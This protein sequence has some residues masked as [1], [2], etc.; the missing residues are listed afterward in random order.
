MTYARLAVSA[1]PERFVDI[2]REMMWVADHQADPQAGDRLSRIICKV[3]AMRAQQ[4]AAAPS[5][6]RDVLSGAQAAPGG[7]HRACVS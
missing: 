5:P 2:L 6:Q 1:M 4:R 7:Q 3:H